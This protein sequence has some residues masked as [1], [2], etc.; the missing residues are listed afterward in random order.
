[1][2]PHLAQLR[3]DQIKDRVKMVDSLSSKSVE[4]H[5]HIDT[6]ELQPVDEVTSD[7]KFILVGLH[8][9]G[10]LGPSILRMF[11][12]NPNACGLVSV[13]CCYMKTTTREDHPPEPVPLGYPMS[14]F[15]S[16]V[17]GHSLSYQAREVACHAIENYAI[18]TR[19]NP[20]HLK[21][22]CFRATMETVLR[23]H[24]LK[25][26]H[27]KLSKKQSKLPFEGYAIAVMKS[28]GLDA[29]LGEYATL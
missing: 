13:G 8:T 16:S 22:H 29:A 26:A 19:D 25:Q 7:D 5:P 1:M 27:V 9:C 14:Q 28:V 3:A 6:L 20:E 2:A 10:D 15:V 23:Q 12:E 4:P 11:T 24:G 18:R 17:P 21:V